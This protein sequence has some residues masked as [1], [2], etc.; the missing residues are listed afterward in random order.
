MLLHHEPLCNSRY[1]L[2][3]G[4][5]DPEA[6][7]AASSPSVGTRACRRGSRDFSIAAWKSTKRGVPLAKGIPL[8]QQE[9]LMD[10]R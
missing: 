4:S 8:L 6:S 10:C 3:I 1:T 9:E 7:H 2:S 5:T